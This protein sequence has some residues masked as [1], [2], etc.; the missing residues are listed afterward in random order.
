VRRENASGIS[1]KSLVNEKKREV[2]ERKKE[3]E[4]EEN[5]EVGSQS[6]GTRQEWGGSDVGAQDHEY[7]F[8]AVVRG[9]RRR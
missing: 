8:W 2:I 6:G 1:L 3:E 9:G 7:S 5:T 4:S